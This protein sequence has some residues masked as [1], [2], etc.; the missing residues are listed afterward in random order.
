MQGDCMNYILNQCFLKSQPSADYFTIYYN[1]ICGLE[2]NSIN[3]MQKS[4]TMSIQQQSQQE[5]TQDDIT[6]ALFEQLKKT[7]RK[8]VGNIFK[9]VAK[10][11]QNS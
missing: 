5:S 9:H 7:I 8:I 1:L 2:Q 11:E 4:D 10:S 3:K 6:A